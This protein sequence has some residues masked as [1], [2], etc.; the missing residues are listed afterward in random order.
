M[1]LA[2]IPIY[3]AFIWSCRTP[4]AH[5]GDGVMHGVQDRTFLP[6]VVPPSPP[7]KAVCRIAQSVLS[8]RH[9]VLMDWLLMK[10]DMK[11]FVSGYIR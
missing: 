11:I 10:A 6:F 7:G 1:L 8:P 5:A 2:A 9:A 3:A 4:Y